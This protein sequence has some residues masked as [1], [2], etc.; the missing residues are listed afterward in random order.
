[1]DEKGE[2][3]RIENKR[4][5]KRIIKYIVLFYIVTGAL[6]IKLISLMPTVTRT[7]DGVLVTLRFLLTISIR[8]VN[9][10]NN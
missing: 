2:Q 3:E 10:S 6:K 7:L 5:R 8:L 4:A 1:M 9:V